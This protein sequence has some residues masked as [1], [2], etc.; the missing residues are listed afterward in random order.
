MFTR[1]DVHPT[2]TQTE[3]NKQQ[4]FSVIF[5]HLGGCFVTELDVIHVA[6]LIRLQSHQYGHM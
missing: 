2:L 3:F 1:A 4:A 5:I 6:Q